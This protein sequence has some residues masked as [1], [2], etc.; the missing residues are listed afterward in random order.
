MEPSTKRVALCFSGHIRD[1]NYDSLYNNFIQ[2]FI[3]AG[4]EVHTFAFFWNVQGHRS[5]GW[6]GQP[7]FESFKEK[8]QPKAFIVEPF[9]RMGFLQRCTTEQWKTRPHLSCIATS[10]D[11]ASMW[12]T[13][14]RCFQEV[15]SYQK[16]NGFTYD[17]VC[18]LRPD[19]LYDTKLN[20]KE[21]Q[22]IMSR[23]VIYMPRWRGKYY[24]IC[25]EIVDYFGM[26]NYTMMKQYMSTFLNVPKYLSSNDYIHTA[27][28]YLLAQLE[29]CTIERSNMNFSVQR[30]GYVEN[31]MI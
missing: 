31:V 10:G 21:I 13:I 3:E 9:N 30:V 1:F 15:E 16:T 5:I 25:H 28:G 17:V 24:E 14:Y 23:D 11:A 19:I 4:F 27:E 22:D 8:L 18:R 6:Q 2:T 20:I 29:N 12:Y 26:G 7:D